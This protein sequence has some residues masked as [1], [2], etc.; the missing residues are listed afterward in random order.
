M[1]KKVAIGLIV[2]MAIAMMAMFSGCVDKAPDATNATAEVKP[3]VVPS[4][5]DETIINETESPA[6]KPIS[7][8]KKEPTKSAKE[9]TKIRDILDNPEDF[10]NKEVTVVGEVTEGTI[11][12]RFSAEKDFL[13]WGF[14]AWDGT[15]DIPMV[16]KSEI[17]TEDAIEDIMHKYGYGSRVPADHY[18]NYPL[19][20]VPIVNNTMYLKIQGTAVKDD[21]VYIQITSW[22]IEP[23]PAPE[24]P[25]V[26]GV[27][28]IRDIYD[29][30]IDFC[31]NEVIIIGEVTRS[32]G[33]GDEWYYVVQGKTGTIEVSSEIKPP[34][35]FNSA[36]M[37]GI[38]KCDW[39]RLKEIKVSSW[40]YVD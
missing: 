30:P 28:K 33:S 4:I 11:S 16:L 27:T 14:R 6:E 3:E 35:I 39:G 31:D 5:L 19:K 2:V 18:G 9:I 38:V 22:D 13:H 12:V 8:Q 37:Q 32:R 36:R 15:G 29:N 24:P 40:E 23:R 21:D 10:Y 7:E 1:N 34:H 17:R 25:Q 26:K 20:D